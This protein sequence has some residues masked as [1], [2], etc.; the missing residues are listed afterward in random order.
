MPYVELNRTFKTFQP[1]DQDDDSDFE[2]FQTKVTWKE[3]LEF[4]RVILLGEAGSGK[5][6]E[7]R[8]KAGQLEVQGL[9]SFYLTVLDLARSSLPDAVESI[10]AL[11]RWTGSTEPGWFF[12]DSLDEALLNHSTFES[13]LKKLSR[14][15]G[16][17]ITRARIFVS[18][19]P[20]DWAGERDRQT[21]IKY[22]PVPLNEPSELQS[23][24]PRLNKV[25]AAPDYPWIVTLKGLTKD[26]CRDLA[27]GCG[28]T[29]AEEY[30]DAIFAEG[31]ERFSERPS[32]VLDLSEYWKTHGKFGT[33]WEMTKLRTDVKLSLPLNNPLRRTEKLSLAEA[34]AAA[35]RLAAALT[36]THSLEFRAPSQDPDPT[37]TKRALDC[38]PL[39][40]HLDAERIISLFQRGIFTPATYGRLKFHHRTTQEFLAARWFSKQPVSTLL[41][42]FFASSYGVETVRPQFAAIAAWCSLWIEEVRIEM[43]KRRPLAL[44][45]YGDPRSLPIACRRDLLLNLV[46]ESYIPVLNLEPRSIWMFSDA[47][48]DDTIRAL[49][50]HQKL[51]NF[52]IELVEK[53]KIFTCLDLVRGV[54]SNGTEVE[55]MRAIRAM[56][57][58]KDEE[59]LEMV[60]SSVKSSPSIF[61]NGLAAYIAKFLFPEYLNVTELISLIRESNPLREDECRFKE[62]L[63]ELWLACPS[64]EQ[65]GFLSKV[66]ALCSEPP[67]AGGCVSSQKHNEIARH[68]IP[69]ARTALTAIGTEGPTDGLICLL[70]FIERVNHSVDDS[71]P[72]QTPL[73]E[74]LPEFPRIQRALFWAD[75]KELLQELNKP[76]DLRY[77]FNR[78]WLLGDRDLRWLYEDMSNSKTKPERA[79][80]LQQILKVLNRGKQLIS[81]LD[82]LRIA[83][84]A[85]GLESELEEELAL[86]LREADFEDLRAVRN[87]FRP[88]RKDLS[89]AWIEFCVGSA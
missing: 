11:T 27:A 61:P 12:L 59:G 66:V 56:W 48:L 5:S 74:L 42:T 9:S 4:P 19:R 52:L 10:P 36:L 84:E 20:S 2:F 22:L 8:Q 7:L 24:L 58:C 64:G 34:R 32:D 50:N 51:V 83:A 88:K 82:G 21:L 16:T 39:L 31:L 80:C 81:E 73:D 60:A 69:L 79:T 54:F 38:A 87:E 3:L 67:T 46:N 13:A 57:S 41:R 35:E 62:Q 63:P 1:G 43:T 65:D 14:G 75:H 86:I 28:V 78:L 53:G 45:A 55:K 29:N 25:K 26:Q 68:L 6:E 89:E 15:L 70:Q 47:S 71:Y 72:A 18:S 30:V 44:I 49:W 17:N 40:E 85:A 77:D 23:P 33:L 37:L 76:L